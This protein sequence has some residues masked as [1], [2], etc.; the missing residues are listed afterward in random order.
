MDRDGRTEAE[1]KVRHIGVSNFSVAQM[2]R[3]EDR[4]N[5]IAAA[6]V[7][8]CHPRDRGGNSPLCMEQRIGVIVYSPMASGL[9][10]GTM[11]QERVANFEDED[12]R[13][14]A[15]RSRNRCCPAIWR[16]PSC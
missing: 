8:D 7:L 2:E 9:L 1:G 10:T 4:S 12:L 14:N 6:A 13:R 16:W 11:T 3:C 15:K 5:H